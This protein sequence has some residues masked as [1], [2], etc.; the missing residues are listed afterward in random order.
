MMGVCL[1]DLSPVARRHFRRNFAMG[2]VNGAAYGV[3][4]TMIDSALVMSWL[5][6]QLTGSSFI[7]GLISPIRNAGW[8]LPQLF[9]SGYAQRQE[10][11]MPIYHACSVVRSA[12]VA[13]LAA[14]VWFLGPRHPAA[15]LACLLVLISLLALGEGVSGISFLDIV[16]KTIPARRR[17]SF[18]ALRS[19]LGGVLALGSSA[20]VRYVLSDA[21]GLAFPSNF[22]LLFTLAFVA[23]TISVA[24]FSSII[25]PVEPVDARNVPLLAQLRRAWGF[26]RRDRNFARL[27]GAR[28]LLV[29][30]GGMATPFYIV[31]AKDLLGAPASS[32]GTYLLTLT[33]SSILANL[34]WGRISARYGNKMVIT[35]SAVAGL[36][37]P[38]AALAAGSAGSLP[39]FFLPFALQ[40][41]YQSSIMIGQVSFV[42]DIAP[43]GDRPIYI[44]LI[45][46]ILGITSLTLAA[47]GLIVDA[48]GYHA[49]FAIAALFFVLGLGAAL[50]LH[51]PRAARPAAP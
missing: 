33:L 41:V 8:F 12:S 29:V 17:G 32:V 2:V 9:I 35:L 11:K 43:A 5:V 47:S 49:L 14:A 44:G 38:I 18:F 19:F 51:D 24:G 13:L 16:A 30:G 1:D 26:A 4:E 10:R 48:L 15:L 28:T 7:I 39:L 31:Y 36:G 20:A 40:G 50:G 45:N 37:A 21:S 3:A 25:E 27:I 22:A 23:T 46:T 34:V 42:L 6:S